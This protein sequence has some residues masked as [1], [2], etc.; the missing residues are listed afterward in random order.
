MTGA[1]IGEA[2][3]PWIP[4]IVAIIAAFVALTNRNRDSNDRK[5][6][7]WT[8]LANENRSLRGEVDEQ[9]EKISDLTDRLDKFE[10]KT[11]VRIGAL[12]NMLHDTARQWPPNDPGPYFSQ[13]D[14]DAL[15]NTDVPFVWR[16]RVRP[17]K[18]I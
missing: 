13:E 7:S 9:R 6:G 8:D 18:G 17:F 3:V 15:E 12:S 1:Q 10:R 2:V 11:N 5:S 16:N 4:A 14:L